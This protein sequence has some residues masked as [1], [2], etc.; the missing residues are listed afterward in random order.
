MRQNNLGQTTYSLG[1]YNPYIFGGGGGGVFMP[2]RPYIR[3]HSAG[4]QNEPEN[5]EVMA[6]RTAFIS[7]IL[8]SA[9][10]IGQ[11]YSSMHI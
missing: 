4:R 6:E 5:P 8:K 2:D 9:G 11:F 7:S 1:K 3:L 10:P